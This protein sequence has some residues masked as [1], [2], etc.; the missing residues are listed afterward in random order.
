MTRSVQVAAAIEATTSR[1][2]TKHPHLLW[3]DRQRRIISAM[4][5]RVH[6]SILQGIDAIGCEVEADVSGGQE[7]TV[8]LVG[9]AEKAVQESVSRIQAA[10][11]NSTDAHR[12]WAD[13]GELSRGEP[14]VTVNLAP[15]DVKHESNGGITYEVD[16]RLP[17]PCPS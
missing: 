12:D 6:S 11:R 4:I 14:K 5:S 9:L 10:L 15:A 3:P 7:G 13:F 16:S 1:R 8:K 2:A 17:R